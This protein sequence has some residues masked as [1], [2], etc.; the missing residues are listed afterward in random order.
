MLGMDIWGAPNESASRD[1]YR[2]SERYDESCFRDL[3]QPISIEGGAIA[4]RIIAK[5]DAREPSSFVRIS[6]GEGNLVPLAFDVEIG[7]DLLEYCLKRISYIHFGSDEVIV[8][9][10][11][12]FKGLIF[13]SINEADL[14]GFPKIG[15]IAAGF[16]TDDRKKDVRA[17]VGNRCS[18][19]L[20]SRFR[21]V[22]DA[23]FSR[24]L[25]PCYGDILRGEDRIGLIAVYPELA[26]KLQTAF[27]IGSV[28]FVKVPTQAAFIAAADRRNSGHYPDEMERIL[29]EAT[30]DHR[31][32]IYLV[33]AGL[34]GKKY[35][36][37][38][39]RRGGI[40]IDIGSIA[41]IWMGIEARG[42][43]GEFVAKWRL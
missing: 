18:F 26:T 9:N 40:A 13:E 30:V 21:E 31:G 3:A 4:N 23:W 22:S 5:R 2:F 27:G 43:G 1:F 17:L 20:R 16:A 33:A 38:I 41:E 11:D 39:K 36:T 19:M 29:N 34:L 37:E 25:L 7:D 35:A 24:G 32:M 14:L 28:K 10:I 6:D 12:F 42:L 8:D 15:S